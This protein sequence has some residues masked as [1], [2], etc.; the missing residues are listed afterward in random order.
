MMAGAVLCCMVFVTAGIA[1]SYPWNLPSG[2]VIILVAGAAYLLVTL[3][4]WLRKR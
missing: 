3:V 2:P 1:L 4:T